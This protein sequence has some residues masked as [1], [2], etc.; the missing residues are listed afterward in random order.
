MAATRRLSTAAE[1]CTELLTRFG[2]TSKPIS[3]RTQLLDANQLHLLS[4]TLNRPSSSPDPPKNGTPIPP[5][6][7]LVYFT[8]AVPTSSLGLDGTDTVVN[9]LAPFTRRMWAGGHLTWSPSTPLLVGQTVRETTRLISAEPKRLKTGDEMLLVGVE[10]TYSPSDSPDAVAL[11]DRRNWVFRREIDPSSSVPV[12]PRPEEVPLPSPPTGGWAR[13]FTQS[14]VS[15]FRFS[16]LTFNGHKIHYSDEW[17]RGV[18]GHRRAVVHGPLNLINMLNFWG[19]EVGGG[20][21]PRGVEYRAVRPIY[22][23]ERYRVLL[24][25]G[26]KG[27]GGEEGDGRWEV[28]VWDSFGGVGMRG[29]VWG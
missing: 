20:R 10:K 6:H 17:C 13:D 29:V 23:G 8:P 21:M 1:A 12:P 4:L 2:S 25:D 3:T 15:L 7:H 19:D 27:K 14:E 9:P 18:E 5:G 16:A 28:E 26:G 22:V 24:K 11:T